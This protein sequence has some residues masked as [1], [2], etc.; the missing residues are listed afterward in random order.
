MFDQC[1]VLRCLKTNWEMR[2]AAM[3][4]YVLRDDAVRYKK[5]AL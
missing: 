5:V 1:C 3:S 4:E 2:V